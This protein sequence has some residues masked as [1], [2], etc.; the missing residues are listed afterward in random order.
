MYSLRSDIQKEYWRQ[1]FPRFSV[2]SLLVKSKGSQDFFSFRFYLKKRCEKFQRKSD[3]SGQ[4]SQAGPRCTDGYGHSSFLPTLN[5][6]ERTP[7]SCFSLQLPPFSV[8][9]CE[10]LA[11]TLICLRTVLSGYTS[12]SLMDFWL[13]FFP[14]VSCSYQIKIKCPTSRCQLEGTRGQTHRGFFLSLLGGHVVA[15]V[16][17]VWCVQVQVDRQGKVKI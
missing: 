16:F 13:L 14:W 15:V 4:T 11:F 9:L 1:N 7:Q 5:N 10:S 2:I 8:C 3:S 6:S 17:L 12:A